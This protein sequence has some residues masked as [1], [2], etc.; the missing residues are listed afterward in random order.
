[1]SKIQKIIDQMDPE[2][3]LA[4]LSSTIRKLFLLAGADARSRFITSMIGKAG[5]DRVG[6]LVHL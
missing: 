4:E 1:M 6:S 5:D 2:D 3:A